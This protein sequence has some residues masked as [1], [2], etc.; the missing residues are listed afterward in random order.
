[1]KMNLFG[2]TKKKS[3][4]KGAGSRKHDVIFL[5]TKTEGNHTFNCNEV[6]EEYTEVTRAKFKYKDETGY[7]QIKG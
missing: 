2:V 4:P 7:Y 1:M 3:Y 6:L 5:Y